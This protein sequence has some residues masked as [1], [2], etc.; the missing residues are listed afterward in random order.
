MISQAF[1]AIVF[2]LGAI[3]PMPTFETQIELAKVYYYQQ[4]LDEALSVLQKLPPHSPSFEEELLL[5]DIYFSKKDYSAAEE[6][7]KKIVD[8]APNE[9]KKDYILL[10][11]AE[12][13]SW[14]KKYE[15]SIQIY[16]ELIEKH[17][18]DTQLRR[19]YA[20]VLIWAGNLAEA[21]KELEKIMNE[22]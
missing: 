21:Q 5:A 18:Q 2:L 7:Y 4:K 13:F 15:P 22:K 17:P 8:K 20:Q 6:S 1:F 16:K 12:M 14:Q 10:R 9:E 19:K 11:L 3:D